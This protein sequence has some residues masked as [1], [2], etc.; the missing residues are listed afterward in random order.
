MLKKILFPLLQV[1][2]AVCSPVYGQSGQDSSH[3]V[4]GAKMPKD[5]DVLFMSGFG[6]IVKDDSASQQ[7][8]LETL[9]LPMKKEDNNYCHTEEL[10]GAKYFVLWPL[11]QVAESC[12]GT[13]SWPTDIPVPQAAIEFEVKDVAKATEILKTKGYRLLVSNRTEPWGQIVTRFLSPE[14]IL[15]GL[16]YTPWLRKDAK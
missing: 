14:G 3:T 7:L 15:L 8:Y 5:L 6:P 2:L 4:P 1:I 13:K 9:G 12:F 10:A 11:S 16:T